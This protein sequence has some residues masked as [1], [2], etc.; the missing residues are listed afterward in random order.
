MQQINNVGW[1]DV[2][3]RDDSRMAVSEYSRL[4]ETASELANPQSQCPMV[5]ALLGRK[6]KD[7]ALQ[8]LFPRNNIKRH[9][10]D[11][12]IKLCSD[13]VPSNSHFPVLFADGDTGQRNYAPTSKRLQPT[14]HPPGLV[15]L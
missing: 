1:F 8:Q 11:A 12:N 9:D 4:K 10:S 13:L 2:G 14:A 3:M 6:N 15:G 5:C 7:Y